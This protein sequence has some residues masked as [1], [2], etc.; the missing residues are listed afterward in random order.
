MRKAS[1]RQLLHN[2]TGVMRWVED[3]ETVEL[4]KRGKVIAE[5]RPPA[6]RKR[7]KVKMPDFLARV[8][9]YCGDFVLSDDAYRQLR[10]EDERLL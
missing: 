3:G 6:L 2:V 7:R 1:V 8:K 4:T 10:D 9:S 5:L